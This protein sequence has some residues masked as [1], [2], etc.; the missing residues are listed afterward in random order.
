MVLSTAGYAI[1]RFGVGE[2]ENKR[3]YNNFE[4]LK[5]QGEWQLQKQPFNLLTRYLPYDV[6]NIS[7]TGLVSSESFA[8][9]GVYFVALSSEAKIAANE[10]ARNLP[11][12]R[13]QLACL[14]TDADKTQCADLPLKTCQSLVIAINEKK[15]NAA[16]LTDDSEKTETKIY[17]EDNCV[18]I[19]ADTRN[20][21]RAADRL[22]FAIYKII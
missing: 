11:M 9:K 5:V 13:A 15:S 20:L 6:E 12:L 19:K 18:I 21:L 1:N 16:N 7:F 14:E 17:R 3:Y 22:L 8:G 10:I 4:F 2:E